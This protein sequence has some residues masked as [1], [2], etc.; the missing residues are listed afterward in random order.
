M[1]DYAKARETLD[2]IIKENKESK[3]AGARRATKHTTVIVIAEHPA[4]I[5]AQVA[6]MLTA[7]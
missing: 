5:L 3:K 6:D 1:D 7:T 2:R 4:E